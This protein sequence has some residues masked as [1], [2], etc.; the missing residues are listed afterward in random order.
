MSDEADRA[1]ARITD[2]VNDGIAHARHELTRRELL[3]C[4]ACH[5]CLEPL[6]QASGLFCDGECAGDYECA[7]KRK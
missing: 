3:P 5:W 4:G 2:T 7:R 1:D 6:R